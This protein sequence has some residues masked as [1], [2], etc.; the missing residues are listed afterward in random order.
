MNRF[1]RSIIAGSAAGAAIGAY[2]YVRSRRARAR[3]LMGADS[4]DMRA[5]RSARAM[6]T[7]AAGRM[8]TQVGRSIV[9]A[10]EK[11]RAAGR[12][13]RLGRAD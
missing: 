12:R 13:L 1:W 9:G 5:A 2:F 11:T 3:T 8:V 10:G 6:V 7:K 4:E